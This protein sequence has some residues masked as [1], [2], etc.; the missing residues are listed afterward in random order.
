MIHDELAFELLKVQKARL[1]RTMA[2]HLADPDGC[3]MVACPLGRSDLRSELTARVGV[4]AMSEAAR[5]AG[6]P[7]E[8]MFLAHLALRQEQ[9]QPTPALERRREGVRRAAE[10]ALGG[11]AAGHYRK[12][13]ASGAPIGVREADRR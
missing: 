6:T 8:M 13:M 5:I 11:A 2:E 9:S 1:L 3:I 10:K 4:G 7:P 12:E